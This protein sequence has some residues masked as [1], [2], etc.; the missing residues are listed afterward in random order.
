LEIGPIEISPP[1]VKIPILKHGNDLRKLKIPNALRSRIPAISSKFGSILNVDNFQQGVFSLEHLRESGNAVFIEAL[2]DIY[3][4]TPPQ[5]PRDQNSDDSHNSETAFKNLIKTYVSDFE[6]R[7]RKDS[8]SKDID[9]EINVLLKILKQ[10]L[11]EDAVHRAETLILQGKIKWL[12]GEEDVVFPVNLGF[13]DRELVIN[14]Y[15]GSGR[16][17]TAFNVYLKNSVDKK[18]LVMKIYHLHSIM[19]LRREKFMLEKLGRLEFYDE[20]LW[21]LIYRKI[22]GKDLSEVLAD[23]GNQEMYR[24]EYMKL[25]K[26]FYEKTGYIHGDIRPPNVIVDDNTS[27]LHLID[28]GRSQRPHTPKDALEA[29]KYEEKYAQNEYDHILFHGR[30]TKAYI[31]RNASDTSLKD[32]ESYIDSLLSYEQRSDEVQPAVKKYYQHLYSLGKLDRFRYNNYLNGKD[33]YL[34]I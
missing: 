14:N 13:G 4:L 32:I 2:Q 3:S 24:E 1:K 8:F 20:S 22:P 10:F 28:F 16:Y 11:K 23:N 29:L 18:P 6:Q 26:K 17:G 34:D 27:K 30:M 5:S 21:M 12:L 33:M 25:S 15:L 9:G 31:D 19:D 7:F